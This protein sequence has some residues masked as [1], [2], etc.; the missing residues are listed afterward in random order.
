MQ[1]L[2][3]M[4]IPLYNE[5]KNIEKCIQ[6][7]LKQSVQEFGVIFIDDGSTD[8]TL[9][10]LNNI[11]EAT[12]LV[13]DIKILK[14]E[15]Q[16]AA[17]ARQLGLQNTCT[18]YIAMLDCDDS[19][20]PDYVEQFYNSISIA[21]VEPDI[22]IPDLQIQN[23]VGEWRKLEFYTSNDLLL[24]EDCIVNS[25]GQW[26][27][28]GIFACKRDLMLKSTKYYLKYNPDLNYINNDEI[29]TRL[30]F[31]FANSIIRSK[32]IYYYHFNS[33]STTKKVNKDK[34][35]MI[36]NA[37]ILQSIFKDQPYILKKCRI[38]V[39]AVIWSTWRYMQ[40]HRSEL[41]NLDNWI[42]ELS[43]ANQKLNFSDYFY[44][45]ELKRKLQWILLKLNLWRY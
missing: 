29:I 4:I 1:N 25:L 5:V 34:Y 27:I 37:F 20:S 16:G 13:F 32:G 10:E 7:L 2:L 43:K 3:T 11:L 40:S 8:S 19:L 42:N 9:Q 6:V 14:Q 15:N 31:Y 38:E 18:P 41:P 26:R 30:N 44:Y 28:H 12:Q 45:L 39:L 23:E 22:I 33:S 35:L 21:L 17:R 36:R 24:S